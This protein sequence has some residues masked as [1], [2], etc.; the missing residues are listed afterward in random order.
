MGTTGET[1]DL[2][3]QIRTLLGQLGWSQNEF[4]RRFYV[5][6][7][8]ESEY[9]DEAEL[10]AFQERLKKELQRPSTDPLKLNRYLD[11]LI[12]HPSAANLDVSLNRPTPLGAISDELRRGLAAIS[13]EIDKTLK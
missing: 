3:Q 1:T 2:Q 7:T 13:K 4:A 11:Y 6:E 9:D 12:A 5:E 10:R 8:S